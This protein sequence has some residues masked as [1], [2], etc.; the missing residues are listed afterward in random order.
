MQRLKFAVRWSDSDNKNHRK[1][2]DTEKE[3]RRAKDWL[4][5]NDVASVDIAIIMGE[6]EISG[7]PEPSS[8]FP[9]KT[10]PVQQGLI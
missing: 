3:A 9:T 6:R 2:Y 8:M 5:N 4:T 1:V 7:A 10:P